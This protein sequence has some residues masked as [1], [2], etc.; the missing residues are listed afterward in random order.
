[1]AL[2]LTDC[3]VGSWVSLLLNS[4]VIYIYMYTKSRQEDVGY[5]LD[6]NRAICY[7]ALPL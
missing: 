3:S 1:M 6:M 5:D 7:P 4:R 2:S